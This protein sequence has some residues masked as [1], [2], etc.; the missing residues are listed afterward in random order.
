MCKVT[1]S[2]EEG[3]YKTCYIFRESPYSIMKYYKINPNT[4]IVY[5]NGEALSGK[6]LMKQIPEGNPVHLVIKNRTATR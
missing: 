6:D 1:V 4:K 2:D 5:M 3:M